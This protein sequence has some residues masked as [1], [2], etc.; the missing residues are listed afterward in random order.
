MER[1]RLI[2]AANDILSDPDK[3][4]AYDCTGAGWNGRMEHRAHPSHYSWAHT[5][6]EARWSGFDT[7][8]SPFHNATWEDWERWYRRHEKQEPAY[9]SNG[10]FISLVALALV[11]GAVGQTGQ[12]SRHEAL[13]R[14]QVEVKHENATRTLLSHQQESQKAGHREQRLQKFMKDRDIGSPIGLGEKREERV[15]TPLLPEPVLCMSDIQQ[16]GAGRSKSRQNDD[17]G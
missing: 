2:V 4:K 7:N 16:K 3:R 5:S 1:Y 8:D 10:G 17:N 13:F 6:G 9:T 14:Q 15:E 11:L 12:V